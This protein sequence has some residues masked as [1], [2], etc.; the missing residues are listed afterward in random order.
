MFRNL[1]LGQSERIYARRPLL[2]LT[3]NTGADETVCD[4]IAHAYIAIV[5][6]IRARIIVL[7]KQGRD[8]KD[9]TGWSNRMQR[10]M[11]NSAKCQ[12]PLLHGAIRYAAIR[13][14]FCS[15]ELSDYAQ[16]QGGEIQYNECSHQAELAEGNSPTKN[17]CLCNSVHRP[18]HQPSI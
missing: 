7:W 14:G 13:H 15:S 3:R 18:V 12:P 10:L 8:I 1:V 9:W 16:M 17:W 5:C 11:V 2:S 4:C 6:T